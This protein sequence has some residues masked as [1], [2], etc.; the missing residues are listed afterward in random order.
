MC[1]Y[2]FEEAIYDVIR[3]QKKRLS[4]IMT[5]NQNWELYIIDNNDTTKIIL[6]LSNNNTIQQ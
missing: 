3:E 1:E 5:R 6:T 2:C 4:T